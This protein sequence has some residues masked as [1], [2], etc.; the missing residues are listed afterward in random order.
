MDGGVDWIDPAQYRN[1]VTGFFE[2]GNEPSFT[3]KCGEF[4]DYLR[5]W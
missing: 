4:L 2:K 3:I 1:K 5:I